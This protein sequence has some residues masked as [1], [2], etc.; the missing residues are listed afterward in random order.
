MERREK[1]LDDSLAALMECAA[2]RPA[3]SYGGSELLPQPLTIKKRHDFSAREEP[4]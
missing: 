4:G 1:E 3:K 2:M